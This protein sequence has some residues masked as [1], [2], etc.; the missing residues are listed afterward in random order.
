M[1]RLIGLL[2]FAAFAFAPFGGVAG[3]T[4]E[5]G[6]KEYTRI[7]DYKTFATYAAIPVRNDV[8]IVDSRPARKKYD[9]GHVPGAINIPNTFFDKQVDNLPEDKSQALIFYCGGLKCPLSHKSA[10]KAE[11]LGYTNIMVF[12]EGFPAWKSQGN[13]AS[14]SVAFVK[15]LVDSPDGSV[16]VDARPTRKKYDKG[17]VPGAINIPNTFFDKQLDKLP[18]DKETRLIF[19]CGGFKCPLSLK[20]ATKAKA[21]GYTN[22]MLF[23]AGY[24]A[25]VEAFGPGETAA[26]AAPKTAEAAAPTLEAGPDGDTITIASFKEVMAKAPDSIALIDVRDPGEY[27]AAHMPGVKNIPVEELEDQVAGLP[28]DKPL[29]FVCATGARSSEAYDIV[30]MTR[31]DMNVLY[32]DAEIDFMKDGS[33]DITAVAE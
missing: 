32:L 28:S 7:I 31:P 14:V 27:D 11:A 20:S 4:E 2:V 21:L 26:A 23:Q 8:T 24:P 22:V 13:F 3:A 15:K 18:T 6:F 30:K 9:K 16:I 12:A 25:W 29:V 1:K 10:Y 5:K 17:H 33:Y 19:Y